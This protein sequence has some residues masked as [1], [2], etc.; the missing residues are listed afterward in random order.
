M[1]KN[2]RVDIDVWERIMYLK[3]KEN[4]SSASEV[5]REHLPIPEGVCAE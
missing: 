4:K 1:K 3:I 2:L 5:L